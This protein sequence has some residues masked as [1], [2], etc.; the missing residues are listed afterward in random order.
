[1]T[2]SSSSSSIKVKG[3]KAIPIN[4]LLIFQRISVLNTSE[5]VLIYFL[6]FE[7]APYPMSLFKENHIMLKTTKSASYDL[8]ESTSLALNFRT[9][10]CIVDR[11]DLHKVVWGSCKTFLDICNSYTHYI[12]EHF[13]D[14]CTVLFDAY[15]CGH[16]QKL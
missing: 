6:S 16:L 11:G 2:L 5:E 10:V 4:S 3:D 12:K 7:L 1:M 13:G 8:F 14:S 15:D 9:S